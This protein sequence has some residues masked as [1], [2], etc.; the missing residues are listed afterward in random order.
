MP[1]INLPGNAN[2]QED[3]GGNEV[4]TELSCVGAALQAGQAYK[5]AG[6]QG[7]QQQRGPLLMQRQKAVGLFPIYTVPWVS[8]TRESVR[9]VGPQGNA[10]PN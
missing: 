7:K 1:H 4:Q 6:A 10:A 2:E 8:M 3:S 9:L 5:F